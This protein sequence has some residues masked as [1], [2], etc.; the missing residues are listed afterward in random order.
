M[1][2]AQTNEGVYIRASE[3]LV[4]LPVAGYDYSANWVTCTGGTFTR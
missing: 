3:G 4:T 1:G 2:A